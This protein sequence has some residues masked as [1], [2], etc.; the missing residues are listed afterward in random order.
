[1]VTNVSALLWLLFA[2]AEFPPCISVNAYARYGAYGYDHL[3][4]IDN[5]CDKPAE[6]V[7]TTS[8]NPQPIGVRVE[9]ETRET[10]VTFRGSPASEFRAHVRCVLA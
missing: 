2:A 3:V 9:A 6:C 1:M 4:T 8:A 7:V 5:G 10:V